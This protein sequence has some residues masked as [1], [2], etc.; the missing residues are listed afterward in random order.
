MR[1]VSSFPI[2]HLFKIFDCGVHPTWSPLLPGSPTQPTE[3][4]SPSIATRMD[5][6]PGIHQN[7][8]HGEVNGNDENVLQMDYTTEFPGLPAATQGKPAAGAWGQPRAAVRSTT[9]SQVYTLTPDQRASKSMKQFGNEEQ[10]RCQQIAQATQTRIELSE[11]KDGSLTVMI[12]GTRPHVEEAHAKIVRELQTQLSKEIEIPKEHH[13][14]LIGKAGETLRQLEAE[15]NCRIHIPGRDDAHKAIKITG[16]RDG[17][18][19]A[20]AHIKRVSDQQAKLAVEKIRCPK[21]LIP[22]VRGPNNELHDQLVAAH[23]VKINIPPPAATDETIV[24]T[25]EREG[26][27]KVAATLKQIISEKERVVKSVT[28]E[29]ARAQHRYVIGQQR[30]GLHEIL[31]ETG[32]S[33][34]VPNEDQ[35]SDT[36][37]LRGDPAKLGDALAR[38]ISRASSVI[39]AQVAAPTWLHKHLIGPKGTTLAALLPN[40]DKVHVDF[41]DSGAIFLEGPPGEV[42]AVQETLAGEVARLTKDMAIE[43]IKVHP[44]LHRHV[45]GRGGALIGKIKDETGVQITVPNEKTNSDEI[46][47]EGKKAGVQKAVSEIRQIVSKIENEKSR[48]I[49]IEQRFHKLIIG[50]KGGEIQKLRNT[51]PSVV[52]SLPEANKKSDVINLRGDKNEVDNA[53]K[54]LQKIAKDLLESNYQESV[55][56]FKEFIKHIVGKGG[57][58]IRKIRDETNTRIDMPEGGSTDDKIYVT[59]KKEN[60][61][62]AVAQIEKIQSE[63]AS[64]VNLE[65]IIPVKVQSRL[66]GGGRRLILDIQEECGGVHIKF[67]SEKSESEKVTVQGPQADAEKAVALLEKMAKDKLDTHEDTL[68]AKPEFHRFLIGKG[69]SRINKL[70]EQYDVRV[71]FPREDDQDK[72][73]IHLLGKKEDVESTKKELEALIKQLNETVELTVEVP[74][75]Y[76]KNFLLRGAHLVKEIQDSNGGVQISFPKQADGGSTVTIKGSKQCAESAKQRIE[77]VVEDFEHHASIQV[78]IPAQYHRSILAGRG[79]KVHDLQTQHG[80]HIRFPDRRQ[81]NAENGPDA[82]IVTISG[83]DTKCEAAREAL[84]ALVPISKQVTVPFEMHRFL[85]G[86]GGETVR[87]IMQDCDV[88]IAIPK[89]EQQ[90]EE[91]TI[92]GAHE[93]VELAIQAI[94]EK[95]VEFDAQAEDRR[96]KSWELELEIPAI[97]HQKIIGPRGATVNQIRQKHDVQ[98]SLPRGEDR[99]DKIT[100]QGYEANARACAE[101]IEEM[102]AALK[103]MVTQEISLDARFHPRLIGQRGKNLKRVMDEFGVEIT[104]S[105]DDADPNKVVVAG[106]NEDSVWDCIDYLRQEEE[107]Y[108]AE[109][110]DRSQ[111]MSQRAPVAEQKPKQQSVQVKN[112]PWQLSDGDFPEMGGAPA[113]SGTT[114][115]WG[116][117]RRF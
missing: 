110:Q 95:R 56:V 112:A 1:V 64:I 12:K 60:V 115:V 106:K 73:T 66:L 6:G 40:R 104:L 65:V 93:A 10:K 55:P 62:K 11:S 88:N 94:D 85:I 47:V 116:S 27:A 70:R 86:R 48:D 23:S 50:Q 35:N 96:L 83:R 78:E 34:E 63:L 24:I 72:E 43:K 75:K 111:Y 15:T 17:I 21:V 49:I 74:A 2:S 9:V 7:G 52:F 99:S 68:K 51:Y 4:N 57:V 90:T 108:L 114:G 16:P 8:K 103:S 19:K 20:L 92:T 84:L 79:Q 87:K 58:N 105:R 44:T 77:D 113:M 82:N 13:R 80:V 30:S 38:V 37:T 101:E 89:E 29:V 98:I 39:T 18:E 71:M 41:D 107:D 14:I 102:L 31:R 5:H 97:Y 109:H 46:I 69:G 28:C 81:E 117:G 26:V 36:I 76:H 59:G 100:I 32:V 61:E 67:P 42:K 3:R 33:V 22:W 91:I 53:Y 45:I 54:Q 25:G